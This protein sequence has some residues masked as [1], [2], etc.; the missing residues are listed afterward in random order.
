MTYVEACLALVD[1]SCH[2]LEVRL[3]RR[4][5]YA[6]VLEC[7]HPFADLLF[8][9]QMLTVSIDGKQMSICLSVPRNLRR[10]SPP[11]SRTP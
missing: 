11:A 6:P 2:R 9:V 10:Q 5:M 7:H 3:V 1:A 4:W 8:V